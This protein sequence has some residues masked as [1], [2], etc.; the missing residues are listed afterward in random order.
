[1][2]EIRSA[3]REQLLEAARK[4]AQNAYA[5]YSKFRVGAAVLGE[6]GIYIGANVEN[7]SFG[8]TLCAERAAVSAAITASDPNLRAIAVA[9]IDAP[10][11]GPPGSLMPCGAC[12]Q[13]LSELAPN[14][15]LLILGANRDCTA[16]ELLPEA[17]RL[18]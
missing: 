12:R 9:C 13:W 7:A 6:R 10:P 14:A 11:D 2:H 1:M 8:L 17:F 18:D 3:E 15:V 4:A 5:P 16:S